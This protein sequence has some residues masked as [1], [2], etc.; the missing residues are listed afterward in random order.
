MLEK[1]DTKQGARFRKGQ[2]GNP[3]G[4]PRGARNKTTLAV[5]ALLDGEAEVLTRKAIERAKDGDAVALRLCLERI[6]P[7]RKDRPVS[8]ALPKIESAADAGKASTAILT[9][10]ATGDVTPLE[11]EA[12]LRL[13]E[14]HAKVLEVR[15]LEERITTLELK[16]G[17]G[18]HGEQK[19]AP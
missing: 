3:S 12:V 18:S 4:R 1:T 15:D 19:E 5:E 8:F 17:T 10:V 7:P 11:A 9:A 6:L 14:G 13:L 16:A 2:S